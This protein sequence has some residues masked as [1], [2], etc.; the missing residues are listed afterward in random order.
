MASS[1]VAGAYT[2]LVTATSGSLTKTTTVTVTVGA[3]AL[4]VVSAPS[5][6]T[7]SQLNTLTFT[8]TGTGS[9]N[10]S[11]TLTLS[12]SQLPPGA[13]FATVQGTS[14]LSAMFKWT[15]TATVA[16]GTYTAIFAIDDGVS[17]SQA[18]VSITVVASNHLPILVAPGRQNATV[19]G[20]LHFSV[21]ANDPSGAGGPIIL[22]ATGLVSNMVF[23]PSTG[24]FSFTP[25]TTQAGQTFTVNFTATDSNNQSWTSTQSVP[26]QVQSGA[27]GPS[28]GGLCLSCLLPTRMTTTAWLLAIGALIGIVSSI[29]LVHI[30]ASAELATARR[31]M[32]S[33]NAQNQIG[34]AYDSYQTPRRA[35]AHVSRRRDVDEY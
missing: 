35:L 4:P 25:S 8:V 22:S 30:R 10:L 15:P 1:G 23:D 29:A 28:G 6:E 5:A 17:S 12:A 18:I 3:Q 9:S 20:K 11:P 19:G 13:S 14:P 27:S 32:K 7:V 16:P 21:S 31:R 34:R 33:L 26:I 24:D 2:V